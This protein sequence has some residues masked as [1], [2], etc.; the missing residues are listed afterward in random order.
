M[1]IDPSGLYLGLVIDQQ[2]LPVLLT[3]YNYENEINQI[4]DKSVPSPNSI[5][6]YE[7]GTGRL[8]SLLSN[9]FTIST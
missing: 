2:D 5:I 4:P 3:K 9:T 6:F 8:V 1:K 7:V